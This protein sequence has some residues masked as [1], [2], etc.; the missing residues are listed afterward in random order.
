MGEED[1]IVCGALG[2]DEAVWDAISEAK[3]IRFSGNEMSAAIVL[4]ISETDSDYAPR[5]R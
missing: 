5:K 3:G 2:G 1:F 4:G